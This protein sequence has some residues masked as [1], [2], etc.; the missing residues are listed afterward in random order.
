M[1]KYFLNHKV[2][3][4]LKIKPNAELALQVDYLAQQRGKQYVLTVIKRRCLN[5]LIINTAM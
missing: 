3:R 2:R 1:P 4:N 5:C